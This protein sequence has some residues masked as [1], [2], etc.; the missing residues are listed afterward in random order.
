[1]SA[2]Y[3]LSK[4]GR[5]M[6][7]AYRVNQ[8]QNIIDGY[9]IETGVSFRI[10]I[11]YNRFKYIFRNREKMRKQREERA[12]KAADEQSGSTGEQNGIAPDQDN[13]EQ[14]KNNNKN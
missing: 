14:K 8:L 3:R 5:Y 13:I 11:D 10:T 6:V 4:D 2:E 1:L 7:R 12:R 9:V